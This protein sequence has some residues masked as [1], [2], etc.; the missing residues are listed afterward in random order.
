MH[1]AHSKVSTPGCV[2][3][4]HTGQCTQHTHRAVYPA[5]APD[6]VPSIR[7]GQ[8]TQHTQRAVYP[9]YTPDSVPSIHTVYPAHAAACPAE[10]HEAIQGHA[11][12]QQQQQQQQQLQQSVA[13]MADLVAAGRQRAAA[14][15]L[16]VVRQQRG[17]AQCQPVTH[18]GRSS[19]ARCPSSSMPP[20]VLPLPVSDPSVASAKSCC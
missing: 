12:Q 15:L 9:A 18:P 17:A 20:I 10:L 2:P 5:Y 16:A 19:A 8:C 4:I 1:E 13:T 11:A 14:L 7:T 3:S 6:S